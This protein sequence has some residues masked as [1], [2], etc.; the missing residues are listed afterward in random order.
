MAVAAETVM[1]PSTGKVSAAVVIKRLRSVT[2]LIL[3]AYVSTHL[4]NAALGLVSLG[5]QEAGRDWFLA[6][7]RNPVG[8][9]A[10]YG[11]LAIHLGLAFQ[12]IYR[13]RS[14]RMPGWEAA[15]LLL[16]LAI[17]PLLV[18]HDL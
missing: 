1:P 14:L 4:L 17:P 5:G 12:A 7:W 6:L 10:L 15:Q 13:R 3:F 2:G 18:Q 9:V 16:G 11:A 8:T